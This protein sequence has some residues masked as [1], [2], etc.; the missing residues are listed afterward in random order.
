M[1]IVTVVCILLAIGFTA[2]FAMADKAKIDDPNWHWVMDGTRAIYPEQEPNNTCPG[3]AMSCGDI[4]S[5]AYLTAGEQDWY[6]FYANAGD[7]LTMGTD[8]Y[9]GSSV[10][11]Y[12]E[13]YFECGGTIIAQDDDSGPGLFSLISNFAAPYTGYYDLKVRGYGS[14]SAGDYIFFVNCTP[15]GTGACCFVDGHCVVDTQQNCG[16][17]GGSYYGDNTVCNPNP[18]PQPPPPPEND[19]C[20]GAIPI[21]RCSS[22][23]ISGDLTWAHNDYSPTNNC[24]GYSANSKDVTYMLDVVAGDVVHIV[25]TTPSYDGSIYILSDCSNMASCVIGEDDP[26]PETFT[27]NVTTS[28]IYYLIADGYS[29]DAGGPFTIDYTWTCP[30]PQACCFDDGTCQMLMADECVTAGGEPQGNGTTCETVE[31]VVV[32][33]QDT[34]WGQIKS[35][36]R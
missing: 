7:P 27:W 33:V 29:T 36:Y 19:L 11:T 1:R 22:G 15:P 18:C 9:N 31:C 32:P 5:P 26:E 16:T 23:T 13:L 24:T 25:Y 30:S 2:N 28:G 3:Q 20:S 35:Q 21:E 4:I 17:A 34:T 14:T 12:I 10:D 6:R 8:A